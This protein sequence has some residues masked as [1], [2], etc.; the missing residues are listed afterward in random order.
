MRLNNP[1][2]YLGTDVARRTSSGYIISYGAEGRAPNVATRLEHLP[3]T[4]TYSQAREAGLGKG[5]LY[6][7]RE[8][9]ELEAIGRG[10][11]RRR[12]ARLADL[13]L[14]EV[15]LRSQRATICLTSALARHG[16]TD[17]IPRS[18][19]IA[20]PRGERPHATTARVTWHRFDP[21]T[22][23]IGRAIL[24]VEPGLKVGIYS[25][26]RCIIDAFRMRGRE[27]RELG[28]E[29]LRRWLRRKGAQ[30]A[31]LL[32]LAAAFPRAAGILRETLEI[33]L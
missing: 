31:A 4:F 32:S 12:G 24:Q 3:L 26:E 18:L 9:G 5:L 22:F 33:L 6:R 21:R 27:G 14:I 15:A 25:P 16:L 23:E 19:D 7:L 28:L 2:E 17:E 11:Y 8:E 20:I 30:P 29:A 13:E 10:L 1:Q